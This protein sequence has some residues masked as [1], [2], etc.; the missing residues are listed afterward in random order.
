MPKLS[1]LSALARPHHQ[2]V[3]FEVPGL[4]IAE[5]SA[6]VFSLRA[7][8]KQAISGPLSRALEIALPERPNT[9]TTT[10]ESCAVWIEPSAWMLFGPRQFL[11]EAATRLERSEFAGLCLIS[12][13]SGGRTTIELSGRH[14]IDILASGCPLDL[15]PR[16]FGLGQSARS[17]FREIAI[18]LLKTREETYTITCDRSVATTLWDM[19]VDAAKV[20]GYANS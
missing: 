7:A 4:R 12:D 8:R 20:A 13:L 17:L 15:H 1:A 16:A 19:L 14:A 9:F 5:V 11:Q 2:A 10:G 6:A 18:L 3:V